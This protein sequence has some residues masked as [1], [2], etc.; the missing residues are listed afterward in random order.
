MPI[1]LNVLGCSD[2]KVLE[3]GCYCVSR[4]LLSFSKAEDLEQLVNKEILRAMLN[5]LLPGTTNLVGPKI[6]TEFLRVLAHCAKASPTLAAD[7]LKMTI[8]DTLYQI[9]TGVSPPSEEELATNRN[10]SVVIMQALIHRPREHVYETLNVICEILPEL[11]G[12]SFSQDFIVQ[13]IS[14][15]LMNVDEVNSSLLQLVPDSAAEE[16]H[17]KRLELL[18]EC[19]PELKRFAVILLPTLVDAYSSTVNLNVRQKVLSA[20]LKMISN[21]DTDILEEALGKVSFASYL[22]SILS[23]QDNPTLV[24]AAIQASELLLRRLPQIYRYHFHR[25]GVIAEISKLALLKEAD[26]EPVKVKEEVKEEPKDQEEEEPASEDKMVDEV[27]AEDADKHSDDG[28]DDHMTSSPVSSRSSSLSRH[29][30]IN[31]TAA[32]NGLIADRASKFIEAH[33]KDETGAMKGKA[34][35]ILDN[36]KSLSEEL[37]TSADYHT[38][39][40]EL[41]KHFASNSLD[42]ISSFELLNSNIV[43]A[44]LTSL[45]TV[46]GMYNS[47]GFHMVLC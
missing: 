40:N 13:S 6:H 9:L 28:S 46:G 37:R 5:L 16:L 34:T 32:M 31:P 36:L 38:V 35:D 43:E 8:V 14:Q 7:M 18:S 1:L 2:Q 19:K 24:L 23:Q 21:L 27:P 20:Q 33:E 17:K 30:P 47:I 11:R 15:V 39:F 45:G 42:S 10:D 22:A 4:I 25:E 44:L 26:P 12:M 41:A 3:Q 29:L